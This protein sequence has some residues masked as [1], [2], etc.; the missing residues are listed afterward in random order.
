MTPIE[1]LN[2]YF[3]HKKFRE[4]QEQIINA[5]L[6]ASQVLAVLP[7]GAGKSICYQIP[8]ILGNSFSIVISPLIA[9]MQDQV[10]SLNK[11]NKFAAYLNSSLDYNQSRKVLN[12]LS[13]GKI[14]LLFVAPEKLDNPEFGTLVKNLQPDYLFVDEAHCISEWGHNFRPSYRNI[15]EFC[16]KTG[17][18]KIS[19]FTATANP[20]VQRDIINQLKL[21][22]PKIFI[23]GFERKNIRLTVLKETEKKH[24]TF[25]LLSKNKLP[26]I[27]Y[28]ATRKLSEEVAEFLKF[29]KIESAA[30]HAG[31]STDLRR[32]IQDDFLNDRLNVIVAT[33]A[34]GMGIDKPNIRTVIHY[35]MPFSIENYYQ[36]F[37]RAGR[38]GLESNAIML[39]SLQDKAIQKY[40]VESSYPTETDIRMIYNIICDYGKI[41]IGSVKPQAIKLDKGFYDLIKLNKLSVVKLRHCI[42]ILFTSGYIKKNSGRHNKYMVK[43]LLGNDRIKRFVT[44]ESNNLLKDFILLLLQEFGHFIFT[45]HATI[46]IES[47]G[48]IL[49]ISDEQV[50][51]ILQWLNEAGIIDYIEPN[52]DEEIFLVNTRIQAKY[53]ELNTESLTSLI[54]NSKEKL[55]SIVNYANTTDCRFKS[56]INYFGENADD[57]SCGICDNCRG[58]VEENEDT[59]NFLKE[60]I[61][62]T[63]KE[64]KSPFKSKDLI[65]LLLGTSNHPGIKNYSS[66]GRLKH[67][68]KNEL[69]NVIDQLIISDY[70]QA[71]DGT[72]KLSNERQTEVHQID[73]PADESLKYDDYLDLYNNLKDIRKQTANK[74]SQPEELIC[75][76]TVL[77]EIARQNPT[78]PSQLLSINGF[79]QR[80]FNKIGEE[81]LELI[82]RHKATVATRINI[83]GK[84]PENSLKIVELIKKRYSLQDIVAITK[85]PEAV[86]SMQIE[87]I[88]EIENGIDIYALIDKKELVQIEEEIKKGDY[89]IKS[90]KKKLSTQ[91]SYGK[92]RIV[93]AN[94]K[95]FN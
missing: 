15:K 18:T 19:A 40:L 77:Q 76:D 23:S 29:K 86:V 47:F 70:L 87:S 54:L 5:I 4:S 79:S 56:I 51:K 63:L 72:I 21:I 48:K 30:Y 67:Y 13:N 12:E 3:G 60:I 33:N 11:Q 9:L 1:V 90:L 71:F 7:T 28:V 64:A 73:S 94:H 57:Y 22:S 81:F 80:N 75:L 2:Q 59:L 17:I 83:S 69:Q 55:N 84:L 46:Q 95:K 34:F 44:A 52:D 31:M 36:E 65:K 6:D 78:T 91:I 49:E 35:N 14:K 85:L 20:S 82:K 89:D 25:S 16:E 41:A 42:N 38:D 53:L 61:I 88:I 24:K 74:F 37:G 50:I 43:V 39:Y 68:S 62:E 27:I 26:A 66:F 45:N 92:I 10:N 8:A 32:V 93:L 58:E